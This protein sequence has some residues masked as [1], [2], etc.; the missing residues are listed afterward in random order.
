MTAVVVKIEKDK[1][2][3]VVKYFYLKKWTAVQIK[4]ELDKVHGDSTPAL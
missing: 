2:R 1:F 4:T 3:A